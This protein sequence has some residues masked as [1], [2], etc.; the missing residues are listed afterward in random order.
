MEIKNI[1]NESI[2][3]GIPDLFRMINEAV[4]LSLKMF[5]KPISGTGHENCIYDIGDDVIDKS[6]IESIKKYVGDCNYTITPI[7]NKIKNC[8]IILIKVKTEYFTYNDMKVCALVDSRLKGHLSDK[9]LI[10]VIFVTDN[11]K[12]SERQTAKL[13]K[14]ELVHIA[15]KY[16][17]AMLGLHAN[18]GTIEEFLC[19]YIPYIINDDSI[20]AAK[21]MKSEISD[22]NDST[23]GQ[24]NELLDAIIK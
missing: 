14:H 23:R 16:G 12:L 9:S 11:K 17:T 20:N 7:L 6:Q 15:L 1:V 8:T 2:K 3:S 18:S 19:D 24:Y 13:I 5:K 4:G 22:Y 21:T 10:S